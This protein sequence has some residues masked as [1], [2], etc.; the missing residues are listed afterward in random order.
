MGMEWDGVR[1]G[2]WDGV[3]WDGAGMVPGWCWD[4]VGTVLGWDGAG[5]VPGW[6]RDGVGLG[7]CRDGVGMGWCRDG[8]GMVSGWSHRTAEP[9]VGTSRRTAWLEGTPKAT[10]LRAVPRVGPPPL[11]RAAA[12]AARSSTQPASNSRRDWGYQ[13]NER[14]HLTAS[15]PQCRSSL[16]P[17]TSSITSIIINNQTEPQREPRSHW[18]CPAG[19]TRG[20]ITFLSTA[21]GRE[22]AAKPPTATGFGSYSATRKQLNKSPNPLC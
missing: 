11:S 21:K 20:E 10:Y 18:D 15:L 4:G 14:R 22:G 13:C 2:G 1:W 5:M 3:G 8:A 12:L 16:S 6:R 19:G 9:P 7:W 17:R